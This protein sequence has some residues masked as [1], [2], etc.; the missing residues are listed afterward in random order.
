MHLIFF[1]FAYIKPMSSHDHEESSEY[2]SAEV[3]APKTV[4]PPGSLGEAIN[5]FFDR[6]EAMLPTWIGKKWAY[7]ISML[8][9]LLVLLVAWWPIKNMKDEAQT[10]LEHIQWLSTLLM[11]LLVAMILQSK[12]AD[13]VYSFMMVTANKQHIANTHWLGEYAKAIRAS[14][15]LLIPTSV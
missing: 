12:I 2:R 13:I 8:I 6:T 7:I 14:G 4:P 11:T 10:P 1:A 15:T 9:A 5:V 3:E